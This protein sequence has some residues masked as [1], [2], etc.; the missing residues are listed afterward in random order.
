MKTDFTV[1]NI[2]VTT[3]VQIFASWKFPMDINMIKD[4]RS[5]TVKKLPIL[6]L[7]QYFPDMFDQGTS[8]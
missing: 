8:F 6:P 4:L 2:W 1:K 5:P 7:A 3:C